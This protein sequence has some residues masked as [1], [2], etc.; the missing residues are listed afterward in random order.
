MHSTLKVN[1]NAFWMCKLNIYRLI[2]NNEWKSKYINGD[3]V[4][5]KL[6][7]DN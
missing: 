5:V 7:I 3:C 2:Q 1:K 4:I 6:I